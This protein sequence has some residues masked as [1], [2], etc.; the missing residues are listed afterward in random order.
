MN[1]RTQ[2]VDV[3]LAVII[4]QRPRAG[5]VG[6]M[7]LVGSVQDSDCIIVDDIIDTAGTLC[8]AA[9]EL[10][11]FGAKRV[12]AFSTHGLFNGPAAAR[13]EACALEE[14]VVANTVPLRLEVSAVTKKIRVISVGKLL[15]GAI[16]AVHT[17]E[18]VS[19]LFDADVAGN[20]LA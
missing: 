5:E 20:L 3:S 8:K 12:Y 13:I 2:G 7:N 10:K 17:G 9:D 15:D 6:T 14:V 19:A 16:R 4:K 1:E 18:S 11:T